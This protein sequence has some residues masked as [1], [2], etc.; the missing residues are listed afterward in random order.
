MT[1]MAVSMSCKWWKIQKCLLIC[2]TT[3]L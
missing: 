2:H 1:D 3:N